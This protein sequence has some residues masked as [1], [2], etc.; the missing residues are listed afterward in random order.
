M[1][2]LPLTKAKRVTERWRQL[3]ADR[4]NWESWWQELAKYCV[5]RKAEITETKSTG[6]QFDADVYDSTARDSAKI[7][8][9]GLMGHLTSPSVPWFKLRTQDDALMNAEG[10]KDFFSRAEKKIRQ[11]FNGSNFYEQIHEF[12]M[13]IGV[14]GT[15]A[16]YSEEDAKD[17]VRYYSRP[18][19]EIFFEDDERGRL[20]AVYRLFEYTTMQAFERWGNK[21]GKEVVKAVE[22]R[23][24]SGKV[25]YLQYVG[26]REIR[27]PSKQRNKLNM[28]IE[29]V[30]VNLKEELKVDEGGFME[31]PFNIA[32]FSKLP[33]EKHGYS[34]AMDILPDIKSAN[35]MKWTMLRAAAKAVDPP[36]L[37]P[38]EN[39]IL[40]LDF[41]PAAINYKQQTTGAG[42]DEK[43]EVWDYKGNWN[44][45]RESLMDD[46]EI[47]KRGFFTD[48]F[49]LLMDRKKTMTATEVEERVVEKMLIL[50]PVLG[51]L[52]S[53]LL[54]PNIVRT[55]N[56][57]LRNGH[58]GEIPQ[59][60]L[61]EDGYKVEYIG[62]LAKAQKLSEVRSIESFLV[63][64]QGIATLDPQVVHKVNTDA[65]VD[66]IADVLGVDPKILREPEEVAK[67]REELQKQQQIAQQMQM[68]QMAGEAGQSVGKA[69]QEINALEQPQQGGG[70][71]R[72]TGT[73]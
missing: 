64:V 4:G 36:V 8:A 12:Y 30:W 23:E 32:R 2:T 46:R 16:F 69:G 29:S 14:F 13:D 73:A 55:F 11:I 48:L 63:S 53:G 17:I 56:I 45:G 1:A 57:A 27:D 34:P 3:K 41:N 60:L 72:G 68:A 51:R 37:L 50:G 42:S 20:R 62:Q 67:I 25:E 54:E 28:E 61:D 7:F 35:R 65:A 15:S 44:V 43:V 70:N 52:Q 38:H 6:T 26:P 5:P 71:G 22:K 58:L 19:R 66:E 21:A 33:Q 39:F 24:F 59:A 49:L 18:I 40:P 10:V 31:M 47:I 9:A